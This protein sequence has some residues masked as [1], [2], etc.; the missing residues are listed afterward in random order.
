MS[1][2]AQA[3]ERGWTQQEG[4]RWR[5]PE[6]GEV[7]QYGGRW[8]A[9]PPGHDLNSDSPPSYRTMRDAMRVLEDAQ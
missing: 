8:W 5:H 1:A 6:Y 7:E 9:R 4:G 3:R 2:A